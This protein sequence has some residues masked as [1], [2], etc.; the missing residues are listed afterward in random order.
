MAVSL[1]LPE[2][3]SLRLQ[4]LSERTGRSKTSYMI[5]AISDHID[6]LEDMYLAQQRLLDIRAGE[7]TVELERIMAR[8]GLES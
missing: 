7:Q 2:D 1:R 8:Y 6:D 5:E 4:S 3:V